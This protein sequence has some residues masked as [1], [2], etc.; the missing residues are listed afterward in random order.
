MPTVMVWGEDGQP[1]EM[2]FE[3]LKDPGEGNVWVWG[4]NGQPVAVAQA[5]V[6]EVDVTPP[7]KGNVWVWGENGEPVEVAE[8]F[9]PFPL[10]GKSTGPVTPPDEDSP[11][12]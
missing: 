7:A 8:K 1:H 4:E 9:V 6:E 10:L 2:E 5:D 11:D 3:A 12:E